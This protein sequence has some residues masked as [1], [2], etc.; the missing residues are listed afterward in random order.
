M[1]YLKGE[2]C[3]RTPETNPVEAKSCNAQNVYFFPC[4][5]NLSEDLLLIII[6]NENITK[7]CSA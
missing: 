1:F 7:K 6:L 3:F 2:L 4:I 5:L